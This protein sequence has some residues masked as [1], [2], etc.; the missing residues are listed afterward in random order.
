M[1]LT[2]MLRMGRLL[3]A[4]PEL[5]IQLKGLGLAMRSVLTSLVLVLIFLYVFAILIRMTMEE[6]SV[7]QTLHFDSVPK[8]MYTLLIYAFF[9]DALGYLYE[10]L[11]IGGHWG[12]ALV[13]S[14]CVAAAGLA[15][16][17]MLIGVL[18]EVVSGVGVE[19]RAS[20]KRQEVEEKLNIAVERMGCKDGMVTKDNFMQ[21]FDGSNDEHSIA[22]LFGDVGVDLIGLLDFSDFIFHDEL[23]DEGDKILTFNEFVDVLMQLRG[24]KEATVKDMVD[25]RKYLR[26]QIRDLGTER[27]GQL[28]ALQNGISRHHDRLSRKLIMMSDRM[29]SSPLSGIP[30]ALE[31]SAAA[32]AEP[33]TYTGR[34]RNVESALAYAKQELRGLK[35]DIDLTP[36]KAEGHGRR[37]GVT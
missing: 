12:I 33:D 25:L 17:N 22:Q 3:R 23:L 16:Q 10:A 27:S 32:V 21:I 29:G 11:F 5:L 6:G 28:H 18:C 4:V 26:S 37:S 15:M 2:R 7:V 20:L 14:L 8:S 24:D 9:M 13:F 1:R 30:Q 35:G 36:L 34:L 31:A 19:E